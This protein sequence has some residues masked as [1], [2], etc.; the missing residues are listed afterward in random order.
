MHSSTNEP[1]HVG[2]VPSPPD[3]K[4][5]LVASTGGHL[6]QLSRLAPRLGAST[7]SLWMTFDSPQ[8]RSL[9]EGRRTAYLPYV[10]PRD[11]RGTLRAWHRIRAVVVAEHFDAVVSTGAAIA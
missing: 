7:E 6:W 4:L 2:D 9:L 11:W 8:S 10:A 3:K 5:L 1:V